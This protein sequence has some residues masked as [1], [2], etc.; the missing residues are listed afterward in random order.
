MASARI[1]TSAQCPFCFENIDL[2]IDP[3]EEE[4][5]YIEDCSVC[6]R[7]IVVHAHC[8]AGE[9]LSVQVDREND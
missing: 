3:S 7:P 4:S 9:L 2:L 6:C 1:E 8:E 5:V